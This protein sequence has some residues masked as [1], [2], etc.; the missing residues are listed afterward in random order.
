MMYRNR[1]GDQIIAEWLTEGE[2]L[3]LRSVL[4]FGS[5][6]TVT[7]ATNAIASI[8]FV[9][10]PSIHVGNDLGTWYPD[11]KSYTVEKIE[12]QEYITLTIK[13][14]QTMKCLLNMEKNI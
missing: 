6:I 2:Q 8:S 9:G 3:Q 14:T 5:S 11:L 4:K 1:Y 7:P 12:L 10:G 13:T